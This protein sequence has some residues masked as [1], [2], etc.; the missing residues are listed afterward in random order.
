MT[1][2]ILILCLMGLV[3]SAAHAYTE[4]GFAKRER[5]FPVTP[6]PQKEID[7]VNLVDN[8][9]SGDEFR[10]ALTVLQ[11]LAA[12]DGGQMYIYQNTSWHSPEY[13]PLWVDNLKKKGYT[14][15]EVQDPVSLFKKYAR[16]YRGAVLYDDDLGS[17]PVHY[18]KLNALTLYCAENSLIPVSPALNRKLGL[19]VLEDTRGKYLTALSAM[20]WVREKMWDGA[21]RTAICHIHP[22]HMALRDYLVLHRI[23][24]IWIGAEMSPEEKD[25]CY[26]FLDETKANSPVM[27]CW[28]GY[29]EQPAGW[30][31]EPNLQRVCSQMGKYFIVTAGAPN[32]SFHAGLTFHKPDK[33]L[34]SP[35]Q[36]TLDPSKVYICFNI[37]DGDNIQYVQTALIGKNWWQNPM[38]G[39]VPMGWTLNPVACELIPDVVEYYLETAAPSDGFICFPGVGLITPPLYGKNSYGDGEKILDEYIRLSGRYMKKLG[40]TTV[41]FG[42]TSSV[43]LTREDFNRWARV[44]PW[45]TGILGDYGPAIGIARNESSYFVAHDT[46]VARAVYTSPGPLPEG[47][48]PA[49]KQ[50]DMIRSQTPLSRPA[51]MHAAVINWY[52]SPETILK[53][54]RA[55]GDEYVPVTQD[56]LFDLMQQARKQGFLK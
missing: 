4:K 3:F 29:G 14:F 28:G 47:V 39:R 18:Y 10:L 5:V 20:K 24:P 17:D 25:M 38:R 52:G 45:L 40:M 36:L 19:E 22:L 8:E 53:C 43:P 9:Y 27:G 26:A 44:L 15:N 16:Y 34:N 46:P 48:D 1:K 23:L 21:C 50:A 42:D 41:Q 31:N 33:P 6:P 56:E 12:R 54:C 51:F 13:L 55:L 2:A 7:L 35:R 11:G 37:S 32:L 49:K 30:L